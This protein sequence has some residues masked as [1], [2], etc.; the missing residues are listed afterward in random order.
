MK[1][2]VVAKVNGVFVVNVVGVNGVPVKVKLYG[3]DGEPVA[4]VPL[5]VPEVPVVE[6]VPVPVVTEPLPTGMYL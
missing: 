6:D 4:G 3:P 2:G 5:Y 1:K